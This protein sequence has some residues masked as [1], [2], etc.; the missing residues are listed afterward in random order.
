MKRYIEA[1]KRLK[2]MFQG[3]WD[4]L[5]DDVTILKLAYVLNGKPKICVYRCGTMF[6]Y[7]EMRMSDPPFLNDCMCNKSITLKAYL[8][9]QRKGYTFFPL[10]CLRLA[11]ATA[12]K[13]KNTN[14]TPIQKTLIK[15][16]LYGRKS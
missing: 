13:I 4:V 9:M 7:C 3:I 16:E 10:G 5:I 1:D 14:W 6:K 2:R 8:L 11:V 12:E 15:R